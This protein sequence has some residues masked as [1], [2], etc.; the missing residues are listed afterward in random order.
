M[1]AHQPIVPPVGAEEFVARARARLLRSPPAHDGAD[2]PFGDAGD[3]VLNPGHLPR[4]HALKARAAAVLVP[5][6]SHPEG[7]S[8]LLTQRAAG[9]R[10]HGDQVA[11]PGG[12]IDDLD[13]GPRGAALREAEEEIGLKRSFVDIIGYLPP[14]LTGS[15]F[16][17]LP[18]V[19][20]VRPGFKLTINH[21]EVADAFETPQSFLMDEANHERRT[22][23]WKGLQRAFYAIPFGDRNIWGVTAG[24]IRQLY[25]RVYGS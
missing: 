14:Y 12:K 7:A 2:D 18:V 6:V 13:D 3:H 1:T 24:I 9:L 20:L 11:F 15:G 17:I 19:A 10:D 23:E 25:D 21:D 16:R 8:V 5:I 4:E 22:R